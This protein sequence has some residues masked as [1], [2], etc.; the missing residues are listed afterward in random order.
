MESLGPNAGWMIATFVIAYILITVEHVIKINKAA[1]ALLAAIVCW[2]FQLADPNQTF[3]I[4]CNQLSLQVS[5]IAQIVFFLFGALA[6]V[7]TISV[8]N[9]FALI[10]NYIRV[11]SKRQLLW[12][13]GILSFFLSSFLDNLTTT[14]VMISLLNELIESGEDRLIIGG[15][16]V[17]AANAGGAW[18]PIGDVTTTMLWIGG[19]ISTANIMRSLFIP[20]ITCVIVSLTFLTFALKGHFSASET[21]VKK[22]AV[23]PFGTVVFFLGIGALIFVP[24]FKMLTGLPPFMGIFL[25]VGF[26]WLFTDGIHSEIAERKHLKLPAILSRIDLPSTLFFLGILLT[27]SAL[28]TAHILDHL[29]EILNSTIGNTNVIAVLI[30]L[31][32]AVIDNVPLVAASMGMYDLAV[33]P[34]DSVLWEMIAFCAGTGGS[35]LIIGSA[36][37][38]VFMGLERVTFTWYLKRISIPALAGYLAGIGIYLLV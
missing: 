24:I 30:G 5:T 16:V 1:V 33:Y 27:I 10:T 12:I 21:N 29:A 4:G 15:A 26:L 36:A 19:Q 9:G 18:T 25:G 22:K 11:R 28:E 32:S 7:E 35:I 20:S 8:H 37:G 3:E 34:K 14:I 13:I 17:I 38:V 2:I 23:E 6:I 31:F